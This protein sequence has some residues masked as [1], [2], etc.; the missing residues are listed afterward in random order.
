MVRKSFDLAH[1]KAFIAERRC[2]CFGC[3]IQGTKIINIM[4][5][6]GYEKNIV[7]F[8]DNNQKKI[9]LFMTNGIVSYPTIP[10][11]E[12]VELINSDDVIIISSADV[13]NIYA[14]L[15]KYAQLNEVV[16]FGLGEIG[17]HQLI[18]SDYKKVVKESDVPLIPKVLHYFWIG[19]E[20]PDLMKRNIEHWHELCPDYEIREWNERNYDI[21]KK[22]YM[23]QAYEMKKWGFVSDYARLDIIYNFG[24]IY[25]DTDVEMVK[26]PDELLYQ[27]CFGISDCSFLLNLGAGFGAVQGTPIIK[28]FRDYYDTVNFLEKDKSINNQPIQYHTFQVLRKYNYKVN[29]SLQTVNGMNLYPMI[30]AGTNVYTM[31]MRITDRTYFLHYGTSTWLDQNYKNRRKELFQK[32]KNCADVIGYEL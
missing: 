7:A 5:N 29:D 28:E 1:F 8:T 24:G 16:C 13:V 2:F 10:L 26:R 31:Q 32:N 6:W 12:F 27:Q 9:G 17:L 22:S 19:N 30:M 11:S 15:D 3:G 14:Q 20:M 21:S 25:L 4:E 23:L 18:V